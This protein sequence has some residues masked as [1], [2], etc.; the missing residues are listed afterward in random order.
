LKY[1]GANKKNKL[2]A[3]SAFSE[4]V[5]SAT[6]NKWVPKVSSVSAIKKT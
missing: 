6:V 3:L 1:L 5:L 2:P 4:K